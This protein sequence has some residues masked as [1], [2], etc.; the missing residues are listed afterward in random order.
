MRWRT[1][2]REWRWRRTG[3][4]RR[5]G[6]N[7][8][9]ESKRNWFAQGKKR[10]STREQRVRAWWSLSFVLDRRFSSLNWISSSNA[11]ENEHC[12]WSSELDSCCSP[13]LGLV[14]MSSSLFLSRGGGS[15]RQNIVAVAQHGNE[16]EQHDRPEIYSDRWWCTGSSRIE[17]EREMMLFSPHQTE[18][19]QNCYSYSADDRMRSTRI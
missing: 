3:G 11:I 13:S 9:F 4:V 7:G 18:D 5:D 16:L 15:Q 8:W 2:P 6:A 14:T 17:R 12:C 19:E 1:G 10:W